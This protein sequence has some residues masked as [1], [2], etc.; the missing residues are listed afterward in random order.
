MMNIPGVAFPLVQ[1]L[2][3]KW[4]NPEPS[5]LLALPPRNE[6]IPRDFTLRGEAAATW[7]AAAAARAAGE[8]AP[9]PP[10][11]ASAPPAL[12]SATDRCRVWQ[13]LDT[14]FLQPRASAFFA[15]TSPKAHFP[16]ARHNALTQLTLKLLEDTLA[17]TSYLA[18]VAGLRSHVNPS[19]DRFEVKVDGFS[20][21]LPLLAGRVF[22]SLTEL[23]AALAAGG[24]RFGRVREELEKKFRN[25]LIKPIKH[26]TYLRLT[27]LRERVWANESLL[28][29]VRGATEAD[30][31]AHL[32]DVLAASHVEAR[33]VL[34]LIHDDTSPR[35]C[36]PDVNLH[37][38]LALA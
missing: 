4:E 14:R 19:G 30:V 11:S 38:R 20:E 32:K 21:K 24:D 16:S 7:A 25:A 22:A 9:A 15:V 26:A 31:V 36:F 29:A 35:T 6:Y 2:L 37:R 23:P 5:P 33:V 3:A 13:K 34:S 10:A 17:E 8:P 27:A 28:E 1:D 12:L 18:D